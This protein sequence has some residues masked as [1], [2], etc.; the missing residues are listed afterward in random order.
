MP[1]DRKHP[2]LAPILTD[3][4][5]EALTLG[6][7]VLR[8]TRL[9]MARPGFLLNPQVFVQ[10][11]LKERIERERRFA[12]A[13]HFI[14]S[15]GSGKAAYDKNP[16][17]PKAPAEWADGDTVA[18]HIAYGN[19]IMCTHDFGKSQPNSVFGP[20]MRKKLVDRFGVKFATISEL[21]ATLESTLTKTAN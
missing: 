18:A 14:Q 13:L 3:I 21:A 1:D 8:A 15:S 4:A 20:V 17:C 10:E 5:E 9:G 7:R 19:D 6:F 11:S 16:T 12:E 2:A